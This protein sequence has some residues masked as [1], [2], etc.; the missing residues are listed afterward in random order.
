MISDKLG[1]LNKSDKLRKDEI[2]D[3]L[4]LYQITDGL[5]FGTDALML[6]DFICA[7]SMGAYKTGVEFGAGSGVI[8]LLLAVREKIKLIYSLEI[9]DI[10]AELA[11]YNVQVNKLDDKIKIIC[12]DLKNCDDL[13][14][15][16]TRIL[17]HTAD[18]IFTN[19]PYIKYTPEA[20]TSGKLSPLDYKNIARREIACNIFDIVKSAERLL[21]NGGDFYIV[22]RPDRLQSLF[23]AM[24]AHNI[25]PKKIKFVFAGKAGED[26]PAKPASLVLIKGRQGAGEGLIAENIFV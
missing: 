9:Q 19:P 18:M 7:E 8:S 20:G 13:Y 10:Y 22:Y 16:G 24:T 1:K 6:A 11:N 12:A 14:H 3:K 26:K 5:L 17:P 15:A 21:K 23:A 2:N 25:T 4:T